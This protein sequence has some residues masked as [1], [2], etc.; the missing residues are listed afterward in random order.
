MTLRQVLAGCGKTPIF[1]H[2][3][4]PRIKSGAG[5]GVQNALKRLDSCFVRDT[6]LNPPNPP[7]SKGGEGGFS[8]IRGCH[9]PKRGMGN[10]AG[11]PGVKRG[12]FSNL[13]D[14]LDDCFNSIESNLV[15]P[16]CLNGET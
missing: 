5:A 2:Y 3:G 4:E 16:Q 1:R 14:S 10:F 9:A 12:F 15:P 13:L 11:R 7:L 6:P 8:S